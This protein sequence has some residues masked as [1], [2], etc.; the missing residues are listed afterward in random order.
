MPGLAGH[1]EE[2]AFG[3]ASLVGRNHVAEAHEVVHRLLQAEK[4]LGPGIR[5]VAAHNGCP[6]LGGHGA[7]AGVGEEVDQDVARADQEKVVPGSLE[8]A[9]P[10]LGS[11]LAQRLDALDAERFD[12]RA[13]DRNCS[14]WHGDI[15]LQ[16]VMKLA[17]LFLPS[18]MFAQGTATDYARSGALREKLQNQTVNVAGPATWIGSTDRF[19]YRKSVKGGAEF[20]VVDAATQEKRPAF[21]HAKLAAALGGKSTAVNLP[22]NEFLFVDD[23]KAIT[24]TA[25]GTQ[26]RCTLA[27]YACRKTGSTGG[28]RGGRGGGRGPAPFDDGLET[29]SEPEN[30]V[31]DGMALEY[32]QL[33]TGAP[34]QI[35]TFAAFG[36]APPGETRL[37]PDEK[38]EVYLNNYNV[39]VRKKG[40]TKGE[41][42]S[43]DGSEGNYYTLPSIAWSPDSKHLV[44]YRVRR[45]G[46]KREIHYVESSPADQLQPKHSTREYAKPGDAVD[47]A[48]PVLFDVDTKQA[49]RHRQ[50]AVPESVRLTPPVWRKD[51]RA[52]PSNTISAAIRSI[53]SSKWTPRPARRAP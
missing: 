40:E 13:H 36:P 29:P 37:S 42:L 8:V 9:F 27:D 39:M 14:V 31:E 17:L 43:F 26:W 12:D 19:W 47:I 35:N 21:D 53:A 16:S 3:R 18:L 20:V 48:Q 49:D 34:P 11:R 24:F 1:R 28:G 22:F 10:L 44:A 50:R 7:G 23:E 52:S 32:P 5:F 45:P 51:S 4:G 2:D 38:W 30:N 25:E 46:Y 6:L 41:R 15:I 33:A